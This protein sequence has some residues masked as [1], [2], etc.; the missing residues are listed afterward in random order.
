[1]ATEQRTPR[2]LSTARFP[3]PLVIARC[4]PR[5]LTPTAAAWLILGLL[6]ALDL[7]WMAAAGLRLTIAQ[8]WPLL[9]RVGLMTGCLLLGYVRGGRRWWGRLGACGQTC[10]Q[11]LA[12]TTTSGVLSYLV[13]TWQFPLIDPLLMHADTALGLDYPAWFAWVQAHPG[14]DRLLGQ[15]YATTWAQ[16]VVCLLVLSLGGAQARVRELF[17]AMTLS[18]LVIIP[19]S[20]LSPAQSAWVTYGLTARVAPAALHWYMAFVALRAG[21]LEALDPSV[22]EGL[23]TF[24]SFHTAMGLLLTV[25]LRDY[26][27]V[28]PL[29]A[30]LN[31]LMILSVPTHG[32][33]YGVDVLAGALVAVGALWGARRLMAHLAEER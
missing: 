7:L 28:W 32:G 1:M 3:C 12:L 33:H 22:I 29:A 24:P 16:L 11:F 21:T 9:L 6:A 8:P 13:V 15:A 4:R 23:I 10:L 20:G 17:W 31:I 14:L 2:M 18:L 19:L 30:C 27:L 5:Q 25:A 26:R